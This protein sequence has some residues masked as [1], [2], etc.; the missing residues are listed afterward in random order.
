MTDEN[1][2][3][4]SFDNGSDQGAGQGLARST[5]AADNQRLTG[6]HLTS[7][8]HAAPRQ[9]TT[10][11]SPLTGE[12]NSFLPGD[13][14]HGDYQLIALL[15]RGGR[16]VVFSCKHLAMEQT[17]A[18][19]ILSGKQ[20]D[21]EAW[22]RFQAEAKALARLNHPGIVRIH[23]MGIHKQE[24]P[25][26]VMDLLSGQTLDLLIAKEGGLS[27]DRCL[28]LFIQAADALDSAH[29][30]G[31]VH[32]HIKPANMMLET[33]PTSGLSST[34]KNDSER[35]KIVDFGIARI[36]Q[37]NLASQSQTATGLVF[38]TPYYMS[39]E[40]CLGLRSD[41]RSDIY[42][43][44]CA[45]FEALTGVVPFP[46]E[47][48]FQTFLYHQ[49]RP[50]P[51]LQAM[52]PGRSFPADLEEAVAKMLKKNLAERYQTM[53][54]VKHDLERIRDGK[55]I[56]E[57]AINLGDTLEAHPI[58][59]S[60]KAGVGVESKKLSRGAI[61]VGVITGLTLTTVAIAVL[62]SIKP[63]NLT[64]IGILATTKGARTAAATSP[65]GAVLFESA[66]E[67]K[68]KTAWLHPCSSNSARQTIKIFARNAQT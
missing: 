38:G 36:A 58:H 63:D 26:Y 41:R 42:S 25:Y 59:R 56:I 44:G 61:V 21:S 39:P 22:S 32:R 68:T 19:K 6:M 20:L 30:N 29:A 33:G 43:L 2:R 34:Q 15:G 9:D 17:Y 50:A 4:K 31:I 48:A 10:L 1:K 62:A 64:K 47:N 35:L 54:Q 37:Q 14:I 28:G 3:Q 49:N 55:P 11:F 16:G 66:E 46:G 13:I 57:K 45:L 8:A 27:V 7:A 18:L 60:I 40:Q 5:R 52:A 23:N 65:Q 53:A 67:K 24:F 12:N 51:T